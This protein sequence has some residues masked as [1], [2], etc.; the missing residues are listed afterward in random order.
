MIR[1]PPDMRE[2]YPHKGMVERPAVPPMC[3]SGLL[4]SLMLSN[5]IAGF[6]EQIEMRNATDTGRSYE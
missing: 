5:D 1:K 4:Q 6:I 3:M 2:T